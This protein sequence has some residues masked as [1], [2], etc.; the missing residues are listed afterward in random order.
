MPVPICSD[1]SKPLVRSMDLASQLIA[2]TMRGAKHEVFDM[3][4]NGF[5]NAGPVAPR[6]PRCAQPMVAH[7]EDGILV[8]DAVRERRP[9]FGPPR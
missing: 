4:T 3:P 9:V 1:P 7:L 2:P 5:D 6:C 8:C